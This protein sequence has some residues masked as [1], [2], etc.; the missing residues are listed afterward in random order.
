VLEKYGLCGGIKLLEEYCKIEG[1]DIVIRMPI[2]AFTGG[3]IRSEYADRC[4]MWSS[5]YQ[6]DYWQIVDAKLFAKDLL[7]SLVAESEDGSSI[8]SNAF[9]KSFEDLMEYSFSDGVKAGDD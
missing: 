9:D 8:L 5:K 2:D 3:V 6:S 7:S 4:A 1:D